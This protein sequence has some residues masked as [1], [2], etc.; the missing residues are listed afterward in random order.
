MEVETQ[1]LISERLAYLEHRL[2]EKLM[3]LTS[4]VGKLINGLSRSLTD[5]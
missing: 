3:E 2:V 5:R 4:E 1:I